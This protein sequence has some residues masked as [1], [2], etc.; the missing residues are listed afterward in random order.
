MAQLKI[1]SVNISEKKGTVKCSVPSINLTFNGVEK[2]AHSG[3]WHR[4]V[5]LLGI[6]SFQKF[7]VM[8][9]RKLAFGEFAEN[10]TTE[11]VTL[12][13][14]KPFDIFR[15]ND[16]ELEVTQIGKKCHGDRCAIYQE[17]GNCV[18]P[19]E[20]IFARVKVPGILKPGDVLEYIPK[21]FKV[22]II[23]LSD[24]ASTGEYEDRSGQQIVERV[25]N[26]FRELDRQFIVRKSVIPDDAEILRFQLEQA[27]NEN[28]DILITTG[29]TGIGPRD[30][31]PDIVKTYLDKEIPGIMEMVRHKY[32]QE[33]PMAYISRSIA[34]VMK[35]TF[36]YTLPGSLKA[37]D[38]YLNEILPLQEHL[39]FM[40]YGIDNH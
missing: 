2:D 29:G 38:E 11:G 33:K 25:E 32:G 3:K 6:E 40:L 17:V 8:A 31:T 21:V 4:Q 34:G 9:G 7:E 22:Q 1:H 14:T 19:K 23:T 13:H 24:R 36:V 5:S 37:V 20:G 10:I 39:F 15:N 27:Q 12:Y 30:I 18:M 16:I 28:I 35:N 26:Y